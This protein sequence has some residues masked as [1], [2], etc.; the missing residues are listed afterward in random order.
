MGQTE[1]AQEAYEQL[2]WKKVFSAGAAA[3]QVGRREEGTHSQDFFCEPN[4]F[5]VS[6]VAG[7]RSRSRLAALH[8]SLQ[9]LPSGGAVRGSAA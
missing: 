7:V 8:H 5:F 3:G 1:T 4:D 9:L 2:T 6:A